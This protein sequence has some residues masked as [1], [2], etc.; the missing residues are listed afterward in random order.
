M[1]KLFSRL[2]DAVSDY[3]AARKGLLPLV[4]I[5]LVVLNLLLQF[6]PGAYFLKDS[7]LL[8]HVGFIISVLGIM[9]A[10]VL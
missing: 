5:I 1:Y 8:L 6:F 9:L 4:G 10:W 7:N 3:L 2:L